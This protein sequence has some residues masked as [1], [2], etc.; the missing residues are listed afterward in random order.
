MLALAVK[1]DIILIDEKSA[2][3]AATDCSLRV[4]GTLGLLEEA[5]ARG[6]LDLARA[7]DG[8]R[9][10]NFRYSPALLKAVLDR[11]GTRQA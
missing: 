6:I 11:L 8:L 1:A 2:Q 3:R 4:T 5:W 7:V 10:T 9:R